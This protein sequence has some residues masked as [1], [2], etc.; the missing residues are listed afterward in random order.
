VSPQ[1][2]AD[3]VAAHLGLGDERGGRAFCGREARILSK[4]QA[5]P[6]YL[7]QPWK[8]IR[9][10]ALQRDHYW[11]QRCQKRPA[12]IVHHLIPRTV[13]QSLELELD[14]LQSVCVICHEQVHPEKGASKQPKKQPDL[15]GIRV[16]SIK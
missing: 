10:A 16:I 6:F 1:H 2:D 15:T 8:A 5:D 13:D 12:K 9:V 11:C 7:S 4:K 3:K 14:N